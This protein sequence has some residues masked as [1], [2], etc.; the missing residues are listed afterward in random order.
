MVKKSSTHIKLGIF[1]TSGLILFAFAIYVIGMNQQ[2]FNKTFHIYGVFSDVSG[3]QE[4]NNVRFAGIKVGVVE[5]I[6]I[7]G[8]TTVSVDIS[9]DEDVRKFIKKDA[10]ALIGTEGLMGNKALILTPGSSDSTEIRAGDTIKTSPP[11]NID[12]M[13]GTVMLTNQNLARITEDL[14]DIVHTVSEG[15]GT[16]GKLLMDTS[17]LNVP[18]NNAIQ[19][20]TDLQDIVATIRAGEGVLGR[21]VADSGAAKTIDTTLV[22]LKEASEN[23]NKLTLKAKKSFLLWGF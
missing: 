11:M 17:F 9:I 5:N 21:L 15:K 8:D 14:S 16:V 23:F 4:G 6:T 18:I 10:I 3:L 22:N 7:V 20:T 13:M 19:V 1:V 12:R 2:F